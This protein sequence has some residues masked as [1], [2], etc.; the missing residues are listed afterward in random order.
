MSNISDLPRD[1]RIESGQAEPAA[2]PDDLDPDLEIEPDEPQGEPEPEIE[3]EEGEGEPE[4][5]AAQPQ[6]QPRGRARGQSFGEQ[7]RR[8]DTKIDELTRQVQQLL[9]ERTQPRQ[10]TQAELAE[11]Q[12]QEDEMLAAMTPA[13]IGR[14]FARKTDETVNQRVQSVALSL[15]DQNDRTNFERTLRDEPRYARYRDRVDELCRLVPGLSRDNALT[16][17]IGEA[18]R[19]NLT[20]ATSRAGRATEAGRAQHRAAPSNGRGDIAPTR[21]RGDDLERRLTNVQI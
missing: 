21:G 6:T 12:R 15:W 3:P 13:E 2:E 4:P 11:Q 18:A 20:R 19:A 17:A 16:Q 7:L 1:T 8:R 5:L 10:P 14:Y 9:T